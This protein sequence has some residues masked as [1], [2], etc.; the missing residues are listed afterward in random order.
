M[1]ESFAFL[2]TG[3][4]AF[5]CGRGRF[6][7]VAEPPVTGI[8]F[9]VNDFSL[10]NP[11][12]WKIPQEFAIVGAEEEFVPGL[13]G[14]MPQVRWEAL[15]ESRFRPVFEDIKGDIADGRIKKSVPVMTERGHVENG[16][17][18]QLAGVVQ[19]LPDPFI[20]YGFVDGEEGFVGATPERLFRLSGLLFETMA[21]AGTAPSEQRDSF[22]VDVKEIHEHEMVA[23]YLVQHL[24]D[25]G[26]VVPEPRECMD[27]GPIVHFLTRISVEMNRFRTIEGLIQRMH[28]TPALGSFPRTLES[29]RKLY[30]YRA[31]L[32]AP[33]RFGAPFGAIVDGEFSS[34]VAIR[35]V[36]WTGDKVCLPSGCGVI[37]ESTLK[38][39]WEELALKRHS[40]K[41]ILGI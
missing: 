38:N 7:S 40:V 36:S 34:V 25:L 28:P 27:L 10:S 26:E 9:Y 15:D 29:L 41:E 32:A 22:L 20:S 17:P 31:E 4:G 2:K 30:D 37:E 6:E 18:G 35:N 21:L 8:A 13:N 33:E 19:R 3:L 14:G 39:E 1:G 12:P 11:L 23:Q 5:V 16:N 24:A